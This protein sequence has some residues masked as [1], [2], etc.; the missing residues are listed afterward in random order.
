MKWIGCLREKCRGLI[1]EI[2]E[3]SVAETCR[4]FLYLLMRLTLICYLAAILVALPFYFQRETGYTTIGSSKSELFQ[5]WG[6]GSARMFVHIFLLYLVF[7]LFCWWKENRK[8]KH[9][10]ALLINRFLDGFSITD[11]FVI[12]YILSLCF[13]YYY[14]PYSEVALMG[15]SGWYMGFVPQMVMAGSYLAVTR[16]L[17]KALVKW[18]AAAMLLVSFGVFL[19][20]VLNRYGVNP[21][22][23]A[24]AG[25]S[26]ISTIGNI[27][28]YCGYWTVLFPVGAGMYLLYEKEYGKE[29]KS[30]YLQRAAL[31]AFTAV[32]FAAGI[33]QGSDSGMLA[34]AATL[35]LMGWL[36]GSSR[37]RLERFFEMLLIFCA[38]L[39]V[40]A[41]V[42]WR[43]PDRNQYITWL[44]RLLVQTPLPWV[45]GL[46]IFLAYV[47][48][49]KGRQ[50]ELCRR[51]F[52]AVWRTLTVLFCAAVL[53]T[54]VAIAVNTKHPGSLGRF[55]EIPLFT[56]SKD[57]G[58]FRGG[59]WRAGVETWLSQDILHK[60][61]GTGP[62]TM[63]SFIYEGSNI[64][65]L[66]AVR[67]QFGNSRL[68]NAHGEWLTVLSNLGVMGLLSFGGMIISAI[69]CFVRAEKK[70]KDG[71]PAGA[72]CA[73][74]G[75]SLFCYTVNN[76]FSFQQVM[77]I[78][79]M[80]LVMGLGGALLRQKKCEDGDREHDQDI[81][82][83]G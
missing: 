63:A 80:F 18:T 70:T 35:L 49:V 42:Q 17:P 5:K 69:V 71:N 4:A 55:S 7:A 24:S 11:K 47:F 6:I 78:T 79:Q 50:G 23:M 21:L 77:N 34:F 1:T 14:S 13:S 58:N 41:V 32:G 56:F 76:I 57:W 22:G 30:L 52:R 12:F 75:I 44:Y 3:M 72:L 64:S 73:A 65:L 43:W 74:C 46:G 2:K 68:T 8:T 48:L 37:E 39:M 82:C 15:T 29:K 67:E 51:L 83:G 26:F 54:A 19:L 10:A 25:P 81:D 33:T 31:G 62:D 45:G 36:A 38:A 66:E 40:L 28:W 60:I 53:L 27:N 59:T 9:K 61:T 20:G 16:L